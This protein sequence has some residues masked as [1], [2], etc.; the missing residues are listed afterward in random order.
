M[1]ESSV[2]VFDAEI[3]RLMATFDTKLETI[4]GVGTTFAAVIFSQIGDDIKKFFSVP[5]L[6]AYAGLYPKSRQ[7]S[8]SKSDDFS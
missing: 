7:S 4:M 2:A 1:F 5:K 6:V 3:A 8:E